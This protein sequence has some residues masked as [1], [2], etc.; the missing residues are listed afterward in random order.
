MKPQK[1]NIDKNQ[2]DIDL[3]VCL[4]VYLIISIV[5][6]LM[7]ENNYTR[8]AAQG[9]PLLLTGL[10]IDFRKYPWFKDITSWIYAWAS[11]LLTVALLYTGDR[12]FVGY[13]PK[14]LFE[15]LNL[16]HAI[17]IFED[18][19]IL[20]IGISMIFNSLCFSTFSK[21]I[22]KPW[23]IILTSIIFTFFA[24]EPR[25]YEDFISIMF[26]AAFLAECVGLSI[27]ILTLSNL[28]QQAP[29]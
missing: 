6:S 17:G 26:L 27:Y 8:L 18:F 21:Y 4:E 5:E 11:G 19:V 15:T 29:L 28:N 23:P 12:V 1:Q 7:L 2:I 22:R 16:K 10:T 14:W 9:L 20:P 13:W 24:T 25:H 3:N